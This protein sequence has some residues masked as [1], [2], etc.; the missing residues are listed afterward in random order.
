[1]PE[2]HP[3]R[4]GAESVTT[5]ESMVVT[6]PYDGHEVARVPKCGPEHVEAAVAAAKAA[7][8]EP[9][10]PWKR[11]EVLDAA[12][13]S[14]ADHRDELAT[15]IAEEA[16]KPI[17]TAR[18][19]AERAVLT[20][21]SAAIEART[22]TGDVVPIDGAQPGS[23]KL[24]FTLRVPRGVVAAISPFNFPLNLVAHKLAPAIAA[25]CAVVLK[26]ASQTPISAIRLHELLMD[27]CGL[28]AGWIN[29]VTGSGGTV[30]DPLVEHEDVAVITFTG[31]PPVG[32]AI[33]A[34][35]AKKKVG[36]ELG[37]NAPVIID[38]SGDWE[39]AVAK[40]AVAGFSHAGQSC[41]S[42][43]RIY[44]HSSLVDR[45]TEA[46]VA[47]VEALVVG[48][49]LDEATD[50][51][52]LISP[53]E[54][55]RVKAWIDEAVGEGATVATGGDQHDRLLTP[56]ILTGITA[57][58]EVSRNEVFGPLVGIAS[59]DDLDDALALA[60]DTRYGLQAAIFTAEL[61][62]ALRAA[63][64]LDF[65]GV[66]VNEVP[67]FRSDQMPYGGVRDSGNTKEGPHYAVREM[68]HERLVVINR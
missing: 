24:A 42:T 45:F 8:A 65:G 34:K 28:P 50:V 2:Q 26:P 1:M 44:V 21:Q 23:G 13:Q 46:L 51:S 25:G 60:N 31:S 15:I 35:G 56:T 61:D 32:W 12:A 64:E 33:A 39:T 58:M 30:G 22:L 17:K 47:K 27:E 67:T 16:A 38:A 7:M 6:S 3:V 59:F 37:N 68:T 53:D 48:D 40:I 11:A 20:F 29:I 55:A 4:I 43:Q 36:L 9:L 49:P 52:A 10:E 18:T 63:H 62:G 54:T 19:E 5:E 41:I 57:D 14:V 66:L